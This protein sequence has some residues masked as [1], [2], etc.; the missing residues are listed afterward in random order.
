MKIQDIE[1]HADGIDNAYEEIREIKA[2]VQSATAFSKTPTIEDANLKLQE[3]ASELGA[4]A[5]INVEYNRGISLTSWK[6]LTAT[7]MAVLIASNETKCPFCAESIKI[8][9]IKCRHCGEKMNA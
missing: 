8:E 5:V 3:K 7:G 6:A 4:N 2:K 1:I 9:A